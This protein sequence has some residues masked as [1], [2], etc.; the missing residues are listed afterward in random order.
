MAQK[1]LLNF[2]D[3]A[4]DCMTAD[5]LTNVVLGENDALNMVEQVPNTGFANT[6][7]SKWTI[8]YGNVFRIWAFLAE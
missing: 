4:R 3:L 8:S 6:F 7:C 5:A 1:L 2:Y